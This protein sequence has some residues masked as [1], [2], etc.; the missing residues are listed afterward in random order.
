MSCSSV[1]CIDN[2]HLADIM[3]KFHSLFFCLF[4]QPIPLHVE[5]LPIH[6]HGELLL[7]PLHVGKPTAE[8]RLGAATMEDQDAD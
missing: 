8:H 3:I 5:L 4:H 7:I 6:L 2:G 1:V